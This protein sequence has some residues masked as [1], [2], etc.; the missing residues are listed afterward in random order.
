MVAVKTLKDEHLAGPE[1][2]DYVRRFKR[3]AQ[4]AAQ[5]VH[6]SIVT[7]FDV[8]PD[9]FAMELLEGT[10][11]QALL[12]QRG[13]LEPTEVY[14]LLRPVAEALDYAHAAGTIHRDVNPGNSM[15]L[16]HARTTV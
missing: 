7:I 16:P 8:G 6:P 13:R 3:E 10:T 14:R 9:F 12:S 2:E 5:L 11:L 4:A 15:V 1:A